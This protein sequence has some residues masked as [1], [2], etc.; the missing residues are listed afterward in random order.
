MC[1]GR[2]KLLNEVEC[3]DKKGFHG[4][5]ADG[6][7]HLMVP[8]KMTISLYYVLVSK[9]LTSACLCVCSQIY[10]CRCT[11]F[12]ICSHTPFIESLSSGFEH[13]L[14]KGLVRVS[15]MFLLSH[16]VLSVVSKSCKR[17]VGLV[18]VLRDD[19]VQ[20]CIDNVFTFVIMP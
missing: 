11:C 9:R 17:F 10:C 8:I 19:M 15:F 5:V 18:I 3:W 14:P 16:S 20:V 2:I 7:A 6:V 4:F 12:D 13:I 1:D